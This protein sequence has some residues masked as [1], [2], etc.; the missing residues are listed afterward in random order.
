VSALTFWLHHRVNRLLRGKLAALHDR[1]SVGQ[2]EARVQRARGCIVPLP[3]VGTL[4]PDLAW[5]VDRDFGQTAVEE[6]RN[7]HLFDAIEN[8][9]VEPRHVIDG[10]ILNNKPLRGALRAIFR[11]P[12]ERG[13]RRILAYINPD[14]GDGPQPDSMNEQPTLYNVLTSS[15]FG[16]PQSQS[17]ADQLEDISEHNRTV[18]SHR[19]NVLNLVNVKTDHEE[20]AKALFGVYRQRRIANTCQLFVLDLLPTVTSSEPGATAAR[21]DADPQSDGTALDNWTGDK[22]P[23]AERRRPDLQEAL[24]VLGKQGK[25]AIQLTFESIKW[26]GWIP[27]DWPE[28]GGDANTVDE[29]WE[30]GLF[31]VEFA[32]RLM[33]DFLRL[34]QRLADIRDSFQKLAE[35]C[36]TKQD[37]EFTSNFAH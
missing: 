22:L 30:W 11:L 17:I 27:R 13:V 26:G 12:R 29:H 33:L 24:A 8:P 4:R 28:P 25:A 3:C 37:E 9:L 19:D 20:L 23:L 10:G 5:A 18:Q 36:R 1:Q 16:I 6:I 34:A 15:L 14:P 35:E 7:A 32:A 31:P 2:L 21:S